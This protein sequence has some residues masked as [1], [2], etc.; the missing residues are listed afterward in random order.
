MESLQIHLI[1]IIRILIATVC[2]ILIGYERHS[3]SKEAGIRTH[4]IVALASAMMMLIS[5]YGFEDSVSFDASRI[6]AQVV[7]GVGFIGAG[8]IFVRHD[9]IQGLTT[10]AGIWATSG[11][12][13][14]IGAGLYSLGIFATILIVTIQFILQKRNF[15]HAPRT[16]IRLMVKARKTASIK[17]ITREFN[18]LGYTCTEIHMVK[19]PGNDDSWALLMEVS[20]LQDV[21]PAILLNE[22]RNSELVKE[23]D[24]AE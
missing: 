15:A 5:K 11:I 19:D 13:M 18:R 1:W 17:D 23:V 3:R 20:T 7:S 12:G 24:I 2:G 14:A 4:T 9:T 8:I 10:A 21:E 16:T 22:M 6:A